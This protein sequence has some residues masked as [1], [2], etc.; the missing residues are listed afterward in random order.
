M[1]RYLLIFGSALAVLM[2]FFA[3]N[4][5]G[6]A[7]RDQHDVDAA[8]TMKS[9]LNAA[10]ARARTNN[11]GTQLQIST[12]HGNWSARLFDVTRAGATQSDLENYPGYGSVKI[13]GGTPGALITVTAAANGT[14]TATQGGATETCPLTLT[15]DGRTMS[16]VC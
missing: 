5:I 15:I 13:P 8:A 3:A 9:A 14:L 10:I 1:A 11:T 6:S 4:R 12:A 16:Y 2:I 7:L